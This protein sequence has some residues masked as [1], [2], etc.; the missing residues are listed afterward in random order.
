[1]MYTI[2]NKCV[3]SDTD[4]FAN[5]STDQ[6]ATATLFHL[7]TR[8]QY[9][10]NEESLPDIIVYTTEDT[11]SI[12]PNDTSIEDTVDS[13]N[14]AK[15]PTQKHPLQENSIH[16]IQCLSGPIRQKYKMS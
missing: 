13:N 3:S 15:T 11:N 2:L 6:Q 7:T 12:M 14:D 4:I 8:L 16:Q 5:T 10:D 1:M 9:I